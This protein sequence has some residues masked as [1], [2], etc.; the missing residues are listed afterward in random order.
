MPDKRPGLRGR[1]TPHNPPNR[2][3]RL[4]YSPDPEAQEDGSR[5]ETHLLR[6]PARTIL[7]Y[8]KSPD[9][10]FTVSLNPYR[11]CEHGCIYCLSGDT[12]IL[13]ADGTTKPLAALRTGDAIYGTVRRGWYRRYA[14]TQVLAQWSTVKPAYRV[15]L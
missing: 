12:L 14:K 1:G 13:M 11:G 8:N 3:E 6:D 4:S 10:G 5:P 9:V 7:S 15:T 2:F